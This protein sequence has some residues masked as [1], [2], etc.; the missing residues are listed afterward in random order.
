MASMP[1]P[2]RRWA[3]L[4]TPTWP[5]GGVNFQRIVHQ[6]ADGVEQKVG[7]AVH[8]HGFIT[9]LQQHNALLLCHRLVG[10]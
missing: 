7:I 8:H 6:I 10:L 3:K 2:G 4:R 9:C 5:P 1:W